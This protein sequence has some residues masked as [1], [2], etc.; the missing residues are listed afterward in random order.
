MSNFLSFLFTPN[1][2]IEL[3]TQE[4]DSVCVCMG[5]PPPKRK[6]LMFLSLNSTI[7]NSL[8][9]YKYVSH[10]FTFFPGL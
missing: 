5:G 2:I 6:I 3:E 9:F 1:C 10:L 4:T 8:V 7:I